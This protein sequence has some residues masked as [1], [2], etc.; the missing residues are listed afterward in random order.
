MGPLYLLTSGKQSA[1]Q[2]KRGQVI[3]QTYIYMVRCSQT[4]PKVVAE[5]T[6]LCVGVTPSPLLLSPLQGQQTS[7]EDTCLRA[8]QCAGHESGGVALQGPCT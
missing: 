4:D 5:V 8:E 7:G 6:L 2:R 1:G 3:N